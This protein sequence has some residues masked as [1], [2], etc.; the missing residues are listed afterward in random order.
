[1]GTDCGEIC[2][3]AC[4]K[5]NG[6]RASLKSVQSSRQSNEMNESRREL[7]DLS[8]WEQRVGGGAAFLPMHTGSV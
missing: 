1:M 6:S 5:V 4:E 8:V 3:L 2:F 7:R